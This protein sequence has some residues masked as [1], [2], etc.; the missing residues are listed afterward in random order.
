MS[1]IVQR[2]FL[3]FLVAIVFVLLFCEVNTNGENATLQWIKQTGTT[4]NDY[5]AGVATDNTGSIY[6]S[7][8]TDGEIEEGKGANAVY[9]AFLMKYNA[10]GSRAWVRQFGS[11][12]ANDVT[13]VATDSSGNVYVIGDAMGRFKGNVYFF[14]MALFLAKY[15]STGTEQWVKE[16]GTTCNY[17]PRAVTTDSFGNIYI[18]G[19]G[20]SR[21]SKQTGGADRD[22]L[23][24]K[25]SS[26][27]ERLW[28]SLQGSD[29]DKLDR[30]FGIAADNNGNIYVCGSTEGDLDGNKN[31][32]DTDAFLAKYDSNGVKLWLKMF[33]TESYDEAYGVAIGPSGYIYVTGDTGGNLGGVAN[34]GNEDLF[35]AKY[36]S[37]GNEVWLR[38]LGGESYEGGVDVA[39]DAK[40]IIYVTGNTNEGLDGNE[41]MGALGDAFLASYSSN[42][43][44][45]WVKLCGTSSNDGAKGIA[46]DGAGGVYIGGITDGSF[47][48]NNNAGQ[49]DAYL[50]KYSTQKVNASN[51]FIASNFYERK[52]SVFD[53]TFQMLM[54]PSVISTTVFAIIVYNRK[55]RK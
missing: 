49:F 10:E 5:V 34:A 14:G 39:V 9:D 29:K 8:K 16:Y 47:S 6:I 3:I 21:L 45:L 32:G 26:S 46:V 13:G 40:D 38:L 24:A 1:C 37:N 48:G 25:Y 15:D 4:E 55:V 44:K 50:A 20:W 30:G 33:G 36:D 52:L 41:Y 42:G 43:T 54:W 2:L 7:G 18:T 51:I 31:A 35:L 23:L 53:A 11:S 28:I 22:L 12:W 17:I 27:G 19:E